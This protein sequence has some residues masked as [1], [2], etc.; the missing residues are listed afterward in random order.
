MPWHLHA[1]VTLFESVMF[2]IEGNFAKSNDSLRHI[3]DQNHDGSRYDNAVKGR[4]HISLIENKIHLYDKNVSSDMYRWE[5][6]QPLSTFEIEVTRRLQGTAAKYFHSIGDFQ[7]ARA[8]LEQHLWLNS[9]QPIRLNTRLL[10]VSRLAEI[11]CELHEPEQAVKAVRSEIDNIQPPNRKGRPFRRLLLVLVDASLELG[12]ADIA[13]ETLRELASIEPPELDDLNDQFLH[14]RRVLLVARASHTTLQ[15]E[16]AI[17]CWEHAR[18]RMQS[19]SI[20]Q[21]RHKWTAVVIHLSLAHCYLEMGDETRT[22]EAWD[23]AVEMSRTERCEYVIPVLSSIW[24]QKVA[25]AI[26]AK[27]GWP[28]RLMRPG[29]KSDITWP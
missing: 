26:H 11:H 21:S 12:R 9:T 16:E 5:G 27:A 3:L 24:L 13:R 23:I 15:F 19:L 18:Q 4:L 28:F 6:I 29:G 20:F 10:I 22:R 1:S 25:T 14:M 17:Q 2:R 8:S 7:T